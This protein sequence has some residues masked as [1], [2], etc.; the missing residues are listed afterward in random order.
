MFGQQ[1]K[2]KELF[3]QNGWELVE[4]REMDDRWYVEMWLIKST[5]SPT[6]CLIFF[7]FETDPELY[8]PTG[9][10]TAYKIGATLKKP[11][12]WLAESKSQFKKFESNDNV[13]IYLEA[14]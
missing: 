14:V 6:D 2:L 11:I 12:D 9:R 3:S 13:E 5:W 10:P 1:N 4:T 8:K 7:T